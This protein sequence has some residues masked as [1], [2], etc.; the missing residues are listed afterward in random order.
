[1]RARALFRLKETDAEG[2]IWDM[3]VWQVPMDARNPEGVRYRLAFIPRGSR[4]PGVLYDNHH[5]KGHHK[6]VAGEESPYRYLGL[7]RLLEDFIREVKVRE[8]DR[9]A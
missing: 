7:P 9:G 4:A 3:V 5:P 1:M 6:H 8:A 2:N